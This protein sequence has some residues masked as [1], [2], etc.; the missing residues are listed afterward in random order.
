MKIITIAALAASLLLA[1]DKKPEPNKL[2]PT[3]VAKWTE[4]NR[5]ARVANVAAQKAG[6][7]L[8][9]LEAEE[10][11]EN[12]LVN[13]NVALKALQDEAGCPACLPQALPDGTL[14]WPKADVKD[15]KDK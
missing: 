2:T 10:A 12:A 4:I 6:L 1:E 14:V 3:Q 13:A 15:Q 11:A 9:K 7:R 8:A 5:Q